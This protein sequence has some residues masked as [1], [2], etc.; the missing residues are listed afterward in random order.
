ML[1]HPTALP[2][3]VDMGGEVKAVEQTTFNANTDSFGGN[4]GS[5][6]LNAATGLIEGILVAGYT[7]YVQ[8]GSCSRPNVCDDDTGCPNFETLVRADK[9]LEFAM[10]LVSQQLRVVVQQRIRSNRFL[11]EII[12]SPDDD[13]TII[14]GSFSTGRTFRIRK[15]KGVFSKKLTVG[16][17]KEFDGSAINMEIETDAGVF[18]RFVELE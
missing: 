1:G 12:L 10:N 18:N 3:K 15:R 5:A 13:S 2:L 8:D 14:T 6:V 11:F 16:K 4:S 7:D 17:K 9:I